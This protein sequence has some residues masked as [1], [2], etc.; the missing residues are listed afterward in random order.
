[1]IKIIIIIIRRRRG[2][3]TGVTKAPLVLMF[4]NYNES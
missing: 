1:M 4:F 2:Y 3:V